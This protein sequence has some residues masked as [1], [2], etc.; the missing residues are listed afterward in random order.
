M[1]FM[2]VFNRPAVSGTGNKVRLVW[3]N[4]LIA[5]ALSASLYGGLGGRALTG[6]QGKGPAWWG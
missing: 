5:S 6:I 3:R 2:N 4:T 1:K